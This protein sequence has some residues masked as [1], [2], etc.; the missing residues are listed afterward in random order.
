MRVSMRYNQIPTPCGIFTYGEVEDYGITIGY[1]GL[2][3]NNT[4][5]SPSPP[6][7]I[8]ESVNALLLNGQY[9][10]STSSSIND[11]VIHTNAELSISQNSSLT[12]NGDITNNGNMLLCSD[13]NEYSSLIVNGSVTGDIKYKRHVNTNSG[14]NDLIAPPVSGQIFS[15]FAIANP[16][17]FSNA[18]NTLYLFGP[19]DKTAEAYITYSNTE[20]ATLDAGIGYR[21]ASTDDGT[22]TFTGA[23]TLGSIGTSILNSGSI[24]P[25]WNLIGNPYTSYI[26]LSDFLLANNSQFDIRSTGIYGYDGDASDG[27]TIW[28]Q[29]YSDANPD[30]IITP[31]QGFL[32]A[33]KDGGGTVNFTSTMQAHGMA[34]DFISGRQN[35]NAIS[36]LKLELSLNNTVRK[37]EFYFSDNASLGLDPGYDAAVFG[38]EAPTPG[39]YSQLVETNEDIDM[40]IQTIHN[41][42]INTV[43]TIP[44]GVNVNAG[45]QLK[46]SIPETSLADTINIFLYDAIENKFTLLNNDSYIITPTE[47]LSG[48]GRFY[49]Q[50]ENETLNISSNALE[51]LNVYSLPSPKQL[52]VK[53]ILKNKTALYLYDAQGRMILFKELNIQTKVQSIDVSN[54]LTGVY[55]V[56]LKNASSNISQKLVIK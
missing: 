30:A 39:I 27:W 13:S 43:T 32:V 36:Y 48:T 12:V 46:I 25:E 37:T 16:N 26:K 19:F 22:F 40:A 21:A 38:G 34:D 28:N 14:G 24:Y 49:L 54:L 17:I 31:G 9:T 55:V 52:V 2:L 42:D 41:D 10:M 8:T 29:A 20:T 44:L 1:D 3:Y 6:S 47:N 23:V 53:G 50:F 11:L 15:D 5:W 7:D 4:A 45:E 18:D 35:T 51:S 33:S 56:D